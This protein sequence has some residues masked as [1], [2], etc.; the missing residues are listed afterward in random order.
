MDSNKEKNIYYLD[1][2]SS[3]QVENNDKDAR[4]WVVKDK[5]GRVIGK[6]D[7]LLVNKNTERVVYLDVEV[8]SSIVE[9]NYKPYGKKATDGVHEFINKDGENHLILPIGLAHLNLES[10]IVFTESIDHK[11]FAETKRIK[12]GVP[13]YREYEIA[14]MD[15]YNRDKND[16]EYPQDDAY[17]DRNEFIAH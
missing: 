12:K 11:T 6:V 8:D 9:A 15:S 17:Y 5:D 3:Y 16:R 4:G 2:L 10:E 13:I 1:E 14:V 7:N